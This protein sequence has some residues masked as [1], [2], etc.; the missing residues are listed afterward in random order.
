MLWN[1]AIICT[2]V[3]V[4]GSMLLALMTD[5]EAFLTDPEKARPE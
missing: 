3:A 2:F 5:R 4:L 1:F